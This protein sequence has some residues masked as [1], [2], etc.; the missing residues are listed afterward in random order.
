MI[1]QIS[2]TNHYFD[3]VCM[4]VCESEI[5]SCKFQNR[6]GKTFCIGTYLVAQDGPVQS[7]TPIYIL[8][9]R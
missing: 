3:T 5:V 1:K 8:P 4:Y 9:K 2:K 6:H 7:A